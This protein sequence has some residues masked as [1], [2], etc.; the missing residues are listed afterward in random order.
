MTGILTLFVLFAAPPSHSVAFL[1]LFG[2]LCTTALGGGETKGEEDQQRVGAAAAG[3]GQ[4]RGRTSGVINTTDGAVGVTDTTALPVRIGEGVEDSSSSTSVIL[5][6][7]Q[8]G[9][10]PS[11]TNSLLVIQGDFLDRGLTILAF[12]WE[13]KKTFASFQVFFSAKTANSLKNVS[14]G[15]LGRSAPKFT[16]Q[17]SPQ[18]F[19][20]LS[21]KSLRR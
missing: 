5:L 4:A 15:N 12:I 19:S 2:T 3:G 14:E 7:T 8:V 18:V 10:S 9:S 20:R 21:S 6:F 11:L 16:R 1:F 13:G 17:S